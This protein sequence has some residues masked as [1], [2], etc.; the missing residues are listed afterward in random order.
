MVSGRQKVTVFIPKVT[1]FIP[2]VTIFIPK[3]TIKKF[4]SNLWY[5]FS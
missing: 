5:I 4:I 1:V 3:V 2:K